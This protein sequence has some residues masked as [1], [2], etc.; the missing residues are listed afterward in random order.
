M[1][2]MSKAPSNQGTGP[3]APSGLSAS[4]RA[5]LEEIRSA[6]V[7]A[8]GMQGENAYPALL[9]RLRC[10]SDVQ[11]LWYARSDLMAALADLH[12]E[13]HA[14]RQLHALTG[15]FRGLLPP[16]LAAQVDRRGARAR[17]R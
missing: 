1:L 9:R 3:A 11:G 10:A 16:G 4:N 12:G 14:H 5:R 2:G 13:R 17:R 8:L 7:R 15:M 6:M